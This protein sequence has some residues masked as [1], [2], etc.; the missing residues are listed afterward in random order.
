MLGKGRRKPAFLR[1]F[2]NASAT[3]VHLSFRLKG[4]LLTPIRQGLHRRSLR[5]P[6][7]RAALGGIMR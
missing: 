6:K 3:F 1:H 2:G 7:A 4:A 5:T